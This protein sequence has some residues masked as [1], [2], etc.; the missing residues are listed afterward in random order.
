MLLTFRTRIVCCFSFKST[1]VGDASS[2]ITKK[3]Q[4][5]LP[6]KVFLLFLTHS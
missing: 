1:A 2:L 5:L 4:E 6:D 3:K